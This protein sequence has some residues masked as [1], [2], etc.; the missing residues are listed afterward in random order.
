MPFCVTEDN[1]LPIGQVTSAGPSVNHSAAVVVVVRFCFRVRPRYPKGGRCQLYLM[2]FSL[3]RDRLASL[4]DFASTAPAQEKPVSS[5]APSTPYGGVRTAVFR[6][7]VRVRRPMAPSW[8][9]SCSAS[10]ASESLQRLIPTGLFCSPTATA[11]TR[12]RYAFG[13]T[14]RHCRLSRYAFR[15]K[16]VPC[17]SVR[18]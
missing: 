13:G 14:V 1:T 3:S 9:I 11:V 18:V 17:V 5:L 7:A 10:S 8:M 4:T 16:A 15:C 2:R 12:T 6:R